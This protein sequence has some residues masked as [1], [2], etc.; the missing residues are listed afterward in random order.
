MSWHFSRA[1]AAASLE[2]TCSA[3]AP[4]ARS[5]ST[6]T[7]AMYWSPGKTTD[8]FRPSRSGMTCEPLTGDRGAE[9]LTWFLAASHAKTSAPTAELTG[10]DSMASTADFGEKWLGSFARYDRDSHSWKTVQ[11]SLFEG[12]IECSGI[13]PRSG[14]MLRGAC[15]PLP[16]LEHDTDVRG[17]GLRLGTPTK[18]MSVRGDAFR[19]GAPTLREFLNGST[20]NPMWVEWL[21]GWP[22]QWTETGA[23]VT[24]R[25]R[26]WRR[27]H[28]AF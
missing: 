14:L 17:S 6:P 24:D 28:G 22:L 4:S 2:G 23:S 16:T 8:A 5:S 15:F 25:F 26:E 11:L 21:M 18:A 13:W 19:Q 27:L 12:S 20:P 3:G 1:L 7:P 9:L 10:A